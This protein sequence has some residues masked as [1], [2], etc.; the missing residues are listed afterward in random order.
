MIGKVRVS[1]QDAA[2]AIAVAAMNRPVATKIG[3]PNSAS[4]GNFCDSHAPRALA[5]KNTINGP[6]SSTSLSSGL[7]PSFFCFCGSDGSRSRMRGFI[8][9]P[10]CA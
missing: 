9:F 1:S 3:P 8:G 2:S 10:S 6:S 5:K 4:T 7:T